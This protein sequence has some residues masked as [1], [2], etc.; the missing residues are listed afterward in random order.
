M[1]Q[2][3]AA[4]GTTTPVPQQRTA[5]E[6][7][8]AERAQAGESVGSVRPVPFDRLLS[9]ATLTPAQASLLAVQLL[10]AAHLRSQ[11]N[12]HSP[13]GARLGTVTLTP[14]GDVDVS[15]AAADEGTP[16]TELLERLLQN[17]RRLPGHPRPEQLVLLHRLEEAAKDPLLDPG[18]RARELDGA[19]ADTLGPGARQRLAGQLAALVDAFAHVAPGTPADVDT[20]LAPRPVR[21]TTAPAAVPATSSAPGSSQPGP[22]RAAPARHAPGRAPRRAPRRSRTL[23][24]R[25]TPR[26][27]ALVVLVLAAVLA[28]SGYVVLRGPGVGFVESLG[29]GGDPTAPATTAPTTPSQQAA[30]QP[31]LRRAQP[32]PT[33]AGRQ[34][35]P[36]T[37]VSV[38]KAASCKPGSLC[39]VRVTVHFRPASTTQSVSWK[40]GAARV[41]KRGITWSPPTTVTAQPGWTTVYA[42]SSVRVPPGRSLALVALTSTPARAQSRPI[43]VAGSSLRC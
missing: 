32:V 7:S 18:A 15:P 17:A 6:E 36:V 14:T 33:L 10:D 43:P 35:G 13:V 30:K 40:V 8:D 28:V 37:G 21:A 19:L 23:L 27:V 31:R 5:T 24:R 11:G 12:G 26:R 25:R 4:A 34:A 39:P 1:P 42:D 41:C 3:A 16:V 22:H 20:L 29:P 2:D 38:Q 9:V